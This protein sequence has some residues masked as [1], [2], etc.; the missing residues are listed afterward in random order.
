MLYISAAPFVFQKRVLTSGWTANF[1]IYIGGFEYGTAKKADEHVRS[2]NGKAPWSGENIVL[3]SGKEK[4]LP[5][6]YRR[7]YHESDDP[8]L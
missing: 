3:L 8:R 2:G 1:E 4:L 5:G 7:K 6:Y